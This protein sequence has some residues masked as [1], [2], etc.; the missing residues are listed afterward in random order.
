MKNYLRLSVSVLV[1]FACFILLCS[2]KSTSHDEAK[3]ILYG[4]T[5]GK[6]KVTKDEAGPCYSVSGKLLKEDYCS[7]Q[8]QAQKDIDSITLPIVHINLN[9]WGEIRMDK[10]NDKVIF[11]TSFCVAGELIKI[12]HNPGFCLKVKLTEKDK[13]T[14]SV[15]GVML[16]T[17]FEGNKPVVYAYPINNVDCK[18]NS[19]VCFYS[20]KTSKPESMTQKQAES[21]AD[22][23]IEYTSH[24]WAYKTK[25]VWI[26]LEDI[27]DNPEI[28]NTAVLEKIKKKY[29]VFNTRDDIPE[30]FKGYGGDKK[31]DGYNGG[32]IY[33]YKITFD[34]ADT[35]TVKFEVY[36]APLDAMG[37]D[38]QYKWNGKE[39]T[40]IFGNS[41]SVWSA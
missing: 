17:S 41:F 9:Q 24:V 21:L 20:Q 30:K 28:L 10:A 23:I 22:H 1:V 19:E 27:K 13:S 8:D 5:T 32:F 26:V 14:V 16:Q 6:I 33:K 38:K 18:L 4:Q 35:I 39:W 7:D 11:E 37:C 12:R 31:N 40:Q 36:I 34:S 15:S 29:Q 2:C 3:P 25:F